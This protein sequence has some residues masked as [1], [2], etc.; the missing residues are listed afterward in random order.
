ME[1]AK[2]MACGADRVTGCPVVMA[3]IFRRPE[4]KGRLRHGVGSVR[5]FKLSY[6]KAAVLIEIAENT[7]CQP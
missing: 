6:G 7:R 1:A 5:A 3:V 2:S 4:Q